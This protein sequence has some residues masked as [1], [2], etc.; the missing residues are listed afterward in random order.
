VGEEHGRVLEPGD[1]AVP[2]LSAVVLTSHPSSVLR[3]RD[4]DERHAAVATLV[5]DLRVAA[6][7]R[8]A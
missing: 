1:Q 2:G 8:G 4:R 6:E 7:L 3:L 5:D